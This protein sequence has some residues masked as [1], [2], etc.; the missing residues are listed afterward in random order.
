[1]STDEEPEIGQGHDD[2]VV[3]THFEELVDRARQL[4]NSRSRSLLAIAG[5]PGAGK[6]TLARALEKRLGVRSMAVGLDGFH[7]SRAHLASIGR[8][9]DIGALDTFD[10]RSFVDLVRRLRNNDHAV[11]APSFD[12]EREE[13][14]PDALRVPTEVRLVLLEGNYLL[15]TE[16]P[17]GELASLFDETWYCDPDEAVRIRNLILR[18]E[19]FGKSEKEA[20][21]WAL[22]PDQRNA[23][24]IARTRRFADVV[25]RLEL[26][27]T[28]NDPKESYS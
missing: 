25:V 17:W 13:P 2:F 11:L 8:L 4:M 3:L 23:D 20:T 16:D 6:S 10:A 28:P 21:D 15:V 7:F 9:E 19:A 27:L 26:L 5:A 12:R 18:H 22:G 14:V 24:L 1:M